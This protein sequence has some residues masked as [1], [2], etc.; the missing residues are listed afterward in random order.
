M[1]AKSSSKAPTCCWNS[2]SS[3]LT[4]WA[5]AWE[6]GEDDREEAEG[7]AVRAGEEGRGDR[8]EEG[9]AAAALGMLL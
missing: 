4:K 7:A 1:K 3:R 6:L 5:P 2:P 9:L 8:A